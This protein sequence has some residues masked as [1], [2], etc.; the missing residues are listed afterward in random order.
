M[1]RYGVGA[2][3]VVVD[4]S[5]LTTRPEPIPSA[6]EAQMPQTPQ[7]IARDRVLELAG[8]ARYRPFVIGYLLNCLSERHWDSLVQAAL[9]YVDGVAAQQTAAERRAQE[10]STERG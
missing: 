6:L 10:V 7:E 5:C 8:D 9:E 4:S 1:R 3:R 2:G